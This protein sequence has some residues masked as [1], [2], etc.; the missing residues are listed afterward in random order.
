MVGRSIDR[1]SARKVATAKPGLHNDG[2]G[3]L[4]Q[5]SESGSKSWLLRY[6]LGGK[7]RDM[8]LGSVHDMSLGDARELR[9]KYRKLLADGI[10]PI[11][12]RRREKLARAISSG[13]SG[14]LRS[15]PRRSIA[16]SRSMKVNLPSR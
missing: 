11:E 7:R 10:D 5:V 1:L 9:E 14:R 13:R 3:L 6:R 15:A 16:V 12:H 8:G 4:L 2:L